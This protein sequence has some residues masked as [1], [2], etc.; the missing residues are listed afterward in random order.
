MKITVVLYDEDG[1]S[2]HASGQIKSDKIEEHHLLERDGKLYGFHRMDGM[3]G[4]FR[5][6]K[7][8]YKI[9]EF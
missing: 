5:K 1:V 8:A 4:H 7:A 6:C 9:T 3:T 2:Q